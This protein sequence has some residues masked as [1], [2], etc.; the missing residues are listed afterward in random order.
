MDPQTINSDSS[1]KTAYIVGAV[2]IV[3]ALG[4]WYYY[5]AQSPLLDTFETSPTAQ[6]QAPLTSGD[7]TADI[8]AD[9]N[10][11]PDDTATLNQN[12]AASAEAV[13]SF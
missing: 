6:E 3:L 13:E 4:L 12:A 2:I 7:T 5:S 11:L 1:G 8:S 10:Q 9:L